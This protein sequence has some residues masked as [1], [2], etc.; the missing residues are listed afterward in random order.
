MGTKVENEL[1]KEDVDGTML[2][3]LR[4]SQADPVPDSLVDCLEAVVG[5]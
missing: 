4:V 3:I 2:Y 5:W 1:F